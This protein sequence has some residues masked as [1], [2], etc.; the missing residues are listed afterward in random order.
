MEAKKAAEVLVPDNVPIEAFVRLV[1]FSSDYVHE[2]L[3]AKC[4][5]T[6][7]PGVWPCEIIEDQTHY[8]RDILAEILG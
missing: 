2:Y 8:Y 3:K 6:N 5:K 4:L 7:P 1:V